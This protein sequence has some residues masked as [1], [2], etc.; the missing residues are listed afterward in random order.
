MTAAD[1]QRRRPA[2]AAGLGLTLLAL[3]TLALAGC[4]HPARRAAPPPPAPVPTA[5]DPATPA[6]LLRVAQAFNDAYDNG[7]FGAV[8]DRWDARSRALIS[9]AEYIRRHQVCA[10]ATHSTAVVTGASRG[11]GGAW[12]V[13]YEISGVRLTDIWFYV[14]HRWVFDIVRSNP[15]A[16]RLYRLPFARYATAT[17][18]SAH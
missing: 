15:G 11:K 2:R 17:G 5:T 4:A 8:Y 16:A 14:R 10:P 3:A 18:C 6:A 7:G 12:L 13:R 1:S 9:R